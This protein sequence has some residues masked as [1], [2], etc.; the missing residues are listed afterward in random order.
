MSLAWDQHAWE[1]EGN[2]GHIRIMQIRY[3]RG[4]CG[5]ASDADGL[6]IVEL[7]T[8]IAIIGILASLL[9]PAFSGA[10]N[11]TRETACLN[12]LRQIGLST[13]FY[14]DD[15]EKKFPPPYVRDLDPV[16]GLWGSK[17][18]LFA[19][20]GKDPK[21]GHFADSFP[22]SKYRPLYSYQ[23]NPEI[24]RCASDRGHRARPQLLICPPYHEYAERSMWETIGSSYMYNT[25]LDSPIDKNR[26]PPQRPVTHLPIGKPLSKLHIGEVENPD[27]HIMVHEPPAR[28]VGRLIVVTAG[29]APK[30][31]VEP[32]WSQWHRGRGRSS[33][34]D[35]LIAPDAFF[36]S[37]LFVDGHVEMLDFTKSIKN[38][39]YYP[40]EETDKWIWYQPGE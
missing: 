17:P 2:A 1:P 27:R 5:I 8:V 30:F 25:H 4:K 11:R 24:F 20:G 7:L 28:P 14:M 9:L 16:S 18:T 35:P 26:V 3:G 12:N 38:D 6:T 21:P 15:N 10:L 32:Y 13:R 34:K 22:S 40:Y 39:P 31:V 33:F 37:T 19:L 36:S 29:K 23:G